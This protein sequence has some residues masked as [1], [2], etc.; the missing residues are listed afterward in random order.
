M[1]VRL[2]SHGA[3]KV[4]RQAADALQARIR[5]TGHRIGTTTQAVETAKTEATRLSAVAR[6]SQ[7]EMLDLADKPDVPDDVRELARTAAKHFSEA[8]TKVDAANASSPAEPD[9]VIENLAAA[10]TSFERAQTAMSLVVG[11]LRVAVAT[12]NR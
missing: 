7:R 11:G 6:E 1:R 9:K 4:A 3:D 10:S 8:R 2:G 5:A 12:G